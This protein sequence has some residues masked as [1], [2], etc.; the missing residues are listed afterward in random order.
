MDN[1]AEVV[2]LQVVGKIFRPLKSKEA[3]FVQTIETFYL[4][5][6]AVRNIR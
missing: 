5:G 3:D 4:V 6:F 2:N 1:K